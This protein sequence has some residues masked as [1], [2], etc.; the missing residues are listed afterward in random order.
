MNPLD[1]LRLMLSGKP[2]PGPVPVIERSQF[3][4]DSMPGP[5]D[6]FLL[7][8]TGGEMPRSFDYEYNLNSNI[9]PRSEF[10]FIPSFFHLHSFYQ[11]SWESQVAANYWIDTVLGIPYEVV[12]REE[13][14]GSYDKTRLRMAQALL[15]KPDPAQDWD[16]EQW[17]RAFL[18]ERII[19]DAN[20]IWPIR[21]YGGE[22]VGWRQV[23]GQ[24][25]KPLVSNQG[26]RPLPPA[27]AYEQFIHGRP[28]KSFTLNE[29]VY[30]PSRPRIWCT[31]GESR[32]EQVL[33]LMAMSS[34]FHKY[35]QSYFTEGNIP[36][37][38]VILDGVYK[39]VVDG[40]TMLEFQRALDETAGMTSAKRRLK[41]I[42]WFAKDVKPIKEFK[43]DATL[44]EWLVRFL[45][46]QFGVP[47]HLFVSTTNKAT[48][49]EI[50]KAIVDTKFRKELIS[51]KNLLDRLLAASGFAEFE[52]ELRQPRDFSEPAVKGILLLAT[53]PTV[54]PD[55][56]PGLAIMTRDEAREEMGLKAAIVQQQQTA[57]QAQD[58]TPPAAPQLQL[59]PPAAA[60]PT[61]T[62][63]M[64]AAPDGVSGAP[65][66]VA[67]PQTGKARNMKTVHHKA[68][69]QQAR[70]AVKALKDIRPV[71]K[72]QQ[73][74]A[75]E[76]ARKKAELMGRTVR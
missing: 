70:L 43:F 67:T 16:Y 40:K 64:K 9:Q 20:A 48:A 15:D 7:S 10:N 71:L 13:F 75:L 5:G 60:D 66:A 74:A 21:T 19:T 72:A 36:E 59:P 17:M 22:T 14:A 29:L 56:T 65:V 39:N 37:S 1:N 33:A 34:I 57:P 11:L 41:I 63:T 68:V 54:N 28:K 2:D 30:S 4:G 18:M 46:V 35:T 42:P 52:L 76:M 26:V 58:A 25:I 55:G 8:E 3:D 69:Q 53:T 50:S 23:D 24:T 73:E 45:C 61:L 27:P 51:I 31:Y 6:P 38:V 47:A 49:E 32:V 44:P 62:A 12:P